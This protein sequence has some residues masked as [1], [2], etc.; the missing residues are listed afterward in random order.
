MQGIPPA[1]T[2]DVSTSESVE[3]TLRRTG[4]R[5]SHFQDDVYELL[6]RRLFSIPS[7]APSESSEWRAGLSL[8]PGLRILPWMPSLPQMANMMGAVAKATPQVREL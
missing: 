3:D 8:H 1:S 5:F 4:E 6:A 2:T 7:L